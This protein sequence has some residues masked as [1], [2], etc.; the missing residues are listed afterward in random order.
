MSGRSRDGPVTR[1]P[2]DAK[3]SNGRISNK[4]L[5]LS[6]N[7]EQEVAEA[8]HNQFSPRTLRP[9]VQVLLLH[10]TEVSPDFEFRI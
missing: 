10:L 9:S 3:E 7:G 1:E 5:P 4:E 8:N 2:V 6:R